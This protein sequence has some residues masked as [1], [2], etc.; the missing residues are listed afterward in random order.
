M[1]LQAIVKSATQSA[2]TAIGDIPRSCT[3][4]PKGATTYVPSTGA[5]TEGSQS[6][7]TVSFVFAHYQINEVDGSIVKTGDQK[8][9]IPVENLTAVPKIEDYL[10][11]NSVRWNVMNVA[12]DPAKALWIL[13]V[14]LA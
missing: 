2:F 6:D 1:G 12:T 10:T 14:R 8:A 4:H 5:V 7:E 11:E 13:Q 9:L 3:Y